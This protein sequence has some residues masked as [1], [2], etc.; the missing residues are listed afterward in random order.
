[1]SYQPPTGYQITIKNIHP[2]TTAMKNMELLS[3]LKS[4]AN[5]A[6]LVSDARAG[7]KSH[8]AKIPFTEEGQAYAAMHRLRGMKLD[9]WHLSI[10]GV[11]RIWEAT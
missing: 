7:G 4:N 9:G 3:G 10:S 1:M 11:S 8:S 2:R 6:T 5:Q